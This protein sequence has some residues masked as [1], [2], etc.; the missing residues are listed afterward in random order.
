MGSGKSQAA[1]TYMNEHPE[2]KFVYITP[3]LD[4]AS[5]ICHNCPASRFTEPSSQLP[6]FSFSKLEHTRHL[7]KEGK[8]VA[9]TH[10]AFRS[11]TKDMIEHI[12]ANEYTLIVDEAVD[13]F[14][15]S[16]YSGGDIKLLE[17]G[18]YVVNEGEKYIWTEKEYEGDRLRDL[19]DM[20]K[21]NNLIPVDK[22]SNGMQC[23]Y[24][25]LPYKVLTSF[26]EVIVLTYLF[27][28][29]EMKYFLDMNG[30]DYKYIGISY[31]DNV[32]RFSDEKDYVPEYVSDIG[33]DIKYTDIKAFYLD[34]IQNKGIAV[35]SLSTIN[36]L[37][38]PIFE[39][40]VKDHIIRS[41]PVAG[42]FS[43]LKKHFG[44]E[45][46]H[47]KALTKE[48]QDSL[49][50]F[51]SSGN[52]SITARNIIITMLGTGIRVGELAGLSR[53]DCDFEKN[54]IH[55]VRT[56]SRS[57]NADGIVEK[58]VT[59]PK[60]RAGTRII[61]ML[62]EVKQA[63]ISQIQHCP[64]PIGLRTQSLDSV[65]GFIFTDKSG[66]PIS[67]AAVNHYIRQAVNAHNKNEELA[68]IKE[69]RKP[70]RLPDISSHILRHSFCT[71]LNEQD[72]NPKVL[73]SLM[74]HAKVTLTLDVYTD[75]SEE[76]KKE[77][78][79]SMAI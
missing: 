20:F 77:A 73:Q 49:M 30:I 22:G 70:I 25:V 18:G 1:I 63:L 51:I 38:H 32:Y 56:F 46:P 72:V 34:L 74:G 68:A 41:N 43:E 12:T 66:L 4:E 75:V 10:S 53:D 62:P 35:S 24:W 52:V 17:D 78:M 21:C 76:K 33:S 69:S 23:Y 6:E 55:I 39:M 16:N 65:S 3:Y 29:Q 59:A 13:V 15:E 26:S 28:S 64:F 61:P 5:R 8:N 58:H 7:L 48:E 40:A 45:A 31:T 54:E 71:R 44:Y 14:Q 60:S 2:K 47:R 36:G 19:F 67:E 9:T 11:Y 79:A 57:K 27:E 37:I 42:V 50:R